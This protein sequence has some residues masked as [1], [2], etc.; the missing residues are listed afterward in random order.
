MNTGQRRNR[1]ARNSDGGLYRVDINSLAITSRPAIALTPT[2]NN[3][4]TP[5]APTFSGQVAH[6]PTMAA[7]STILAS[8]PMTA[9]RRCAP[10]HQLWVV[11]SPDARRRSSHQ[12]TRANPKPS[13]SS[14]TPPASRGQ[15]AALS[16]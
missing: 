11:A 16:R 15:S 1:S 14:S 5:M 9:M 13:S 12:N 2:R 3:S 8:V 4:T 7:S 6:K 10:R